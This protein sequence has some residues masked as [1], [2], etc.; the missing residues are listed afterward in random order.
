LA[1]IDP[2]IPAVKPMSQSALPFADNFP[3]LQ[4][5]P[6]YHHSPV[7]S[8]RPRDTQQSLQIRKHGCKLSPYPLLLSK[9]NNT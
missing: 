2:T 6:G 3:K 5:R 1:V 4:A 9:A 8:S 7:A